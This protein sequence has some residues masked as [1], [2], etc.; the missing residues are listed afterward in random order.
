MDAG[1]NKLSGCW[2]SQLERTRWIDVSGASSVWRFYLEY[3][4]LCWGM[5]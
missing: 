2:G 1:I 3:V 4:E 5:G